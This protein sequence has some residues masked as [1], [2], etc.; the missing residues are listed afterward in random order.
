MAPKAIRSDTANTSSTKTKQPSTSMKRSLDA[1]DDKENE[2]VENLP[3]SKRVAHSPSSK[4]GLISNNPLQSA[5]DSVPNARLE[6][7]ELVGA[8]SGTGV[9]SQ[10]TASSEA[11][12]AETPAQKEA[13]APGKRARRTPLKCVENKPDWAFDVRGYYIGTQAHFIYDT[14]AKDICIQI[15][16]S[17][18]AAHSKVKRQIWANVSFGKQI[19]GVMRFCPGTG[20]DAPPRKMKDFEAA[21]VLKDGCWPGPEPHGQKWWHVKFRGADTLEDEPERAEIMKYDDRRQS[22]R[23][24]KMEDGKLKLTM[25]TL[26]NPREGGPCGVLE[27]VRL[28]LDPPGFSDPGVDTQ[29]KKFQFEEKLPRGEWYLVPVDMLPSDYESD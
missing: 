18:N 8:P 4:N 14:E 17:N 12:T 9:T 1:S 3:K 15:K 16:V 22:I 21:C 27:A 23:F 26:P 28:D 25:L 11:Q 29:W 19:E 13:T 10:P 20:M 2:D 24:D 6:P 7:S 5:R